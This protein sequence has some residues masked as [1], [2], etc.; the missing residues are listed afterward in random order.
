MEVSMR[1]RR[2]GF[3]LVEVSIA[4]GI[5]AFGLL[6]VA[7]M[8][9]QAMRDASKGRHVYTAA[10]IGREQVEQI[11]RVPFSQIA[12]KT[13]AGAAPWMA[14][15]GLV[16]GPMTVSVQQAGGGAAIEKTYNIEWQIST[17]P[18][19]SDLRNV[20]LEVTWT[21]QNQQ[22]V[23]PTRTGLP[24]VALSTIVVNNSR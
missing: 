17:I 16:R 8:Q 23:K 22:G 18:G 7:V 5:L 24:T 13:W 15:V 20:E 9:V 6:M 14:N 12:T 11:Q 3:S 19:V 10:M 2:G 1:K 21:E 4:L